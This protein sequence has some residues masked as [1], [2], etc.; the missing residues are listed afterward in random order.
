V[1]AVVETIL[2]GGDEWALIV[3]IARPKKSSPGVR[4][5]I[6]TYDQ[7]GT[8]RRVI[9]GLPGAAQALLAIPG[10]GPLAAMG[11]QCLTLFALKG[12]LWMTNC[13][14]SVKQGP[15]RVNLGKNL[16][17]DGVGS[18][19]EAKHWFRRLSAG[20]GAGDDSEE[21][22]IHSLHTIA[23]RPSSPSSSPSS[24]P[25]P[26]VCVVRYSSGDGGGEDGGEMYYAAVWKLG[27]PSLGAP[28]RGEMW[29]RVSITTELMPEIPKTVKAYWG[30]GGDGGG[31]G[32]GDGGGDALHLVIAGVTAKN[33]TCITVYDSIP[34]VPL[35]GNGGG[36]VGGG[37]FDMEEKGGESKGCG[38]GG[39]GGAEGATRL[40]I[41]QPNIPLW[42]YEF[43]WKGEGKKGS[44]R[45]SENA[46][47]PVGLEVFPMRTGVGNARSGAMVFVSTCVQQER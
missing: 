3:S 22:D 8:C 29:C 32:S 19:Q 17:P 37:D 10:G 33:Y 30:Y 11:E 18:V 40:D 7:H 12:E 20:E 16:I 24:P 23:A 42:K 39:V 1:Q 36:G 44:A 6:R 34:L 13:C 2:P 4:G 9:T 45:Q 35:V 28:G 47:P 5:E 41:V 14:T 26:L 15:V 43:E 38:G 27:V 21:F 25:S 31:D 46:T